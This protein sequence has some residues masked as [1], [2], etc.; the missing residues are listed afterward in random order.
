MKGLESHSVFSDI[1]AFHE[2]W[3]IVSVRFRSTSG[4]APLGPF[5][6]L[7]GCLAEDAAVSGGLE[8]RGVAG[9][10]DAD[11]EARVKVMK[12]FMGSERFKHTTRPYKAW[13]RAEVHQITWATHS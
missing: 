2:P 10:E 13:N 3:R 7:Y 4:P 12:E 11:F 5:G 6:S 8:M 1:F 9:N